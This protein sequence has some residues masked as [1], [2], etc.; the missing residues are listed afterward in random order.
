[1]AELRSEV[2][3]VGG[4]LI[5]LATAWR[6]AADG[7]Q[8]TVCD[9]TPGS[10]TSSVAAGMLAPVTEVEYGEDALLALNLAG[11]AA[12]PAFAEELE[13]VTGLPAGL[14]RT[15]TLSVAYDAD[16]AAAL[17]RLADY[18]RRL[19]LEVEQLTGRETRKREPLL[20]S[21]VTAGVWVAGDHSVD[22]RQ[23]VAALLRAVELTG[24]Q[25]I[26][27][28]V[29]RVLTTGTTAVGVELDN[30]DTV[31]APHLVAA[32]GPWT[33]QLDGI[34]AELRPPVRPV[35]GE[36]LRL[37]VP[38]AY[39]PALN[40]TVRATARGFSVYLVPRPG[41]ELVV[42]ATTSELGY[43]T[44]VL[45]GGVFALLR[46]ARMVLPVIDELELVETLA[47]LRPATPDN[48]PVLG[49]SGLDGLVWATGHYRNGVLLTPITAQVIAETVRTGVLPELAEPFLASRF[50]SH[51]G[52]PQGAPEEVPKVVR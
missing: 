50:R 11:V 7:I 45:A 41:G 16:D 3:V 8:V 21:G 27:Q 35:K 2:V 28:R 18:Q 32:A 37:Q 36:I 4:G 24:V 29:V 23:T 17:H 13:A 20:A 15:G 14:H 52:R 34:P 49:A 9:P 51:G 1:M 10:Q 5:G 31:L 38:K 44:R 33:A 6:L 19:G 40:H 48:A 12:W 46:D 26:R 39:R 42:G 25:L 43:D 47:G 30:G 22:N